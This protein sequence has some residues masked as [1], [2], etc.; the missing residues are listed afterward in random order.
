MNF[1]F[2]M[3]KLYSSHQNISS[4]VVEGTS[5]VMPVIGESFLCIHGNSM[6]RKT[7]EVQNIILFSP[8]EM[9]I[10]T[11]NSAYNLRFEDGQREDNLDKF[12]W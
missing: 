6:V 9:M 3:E 5:Y 10:V 12:T 11:N 2:T 8:S 4:E 7:S 1:K